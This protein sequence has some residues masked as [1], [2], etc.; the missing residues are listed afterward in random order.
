MV[1]LI[2]IKEKKMKKNFLKV[3]ALLIAA[4]LMV[5]SCTQEVAPV[6]NGLVEVTL[7]TSAARS[8]L[9]YS[10]LSINDVTYRYKLTAQWTPTGDQ[11]AVVGNTENK[12]GAVEGYVALTKGSTSA[13][14]GYVSQGLWEVEVIGSINGTDVLKGTTQVYFNKNNDKVTVYVKPTDTTNSAQIKL[15]VKVNDHD[16]G[17]DYKLYYTIEDINGSVVTGFEEEE[18]TRADVTLQDENKKDTGYRSWTA[19]ATG[20]TSGYYRVTVTMKNTKEGV[21][22][23]EQIVGG[24]TKG[25]LLFSGDTT[26]ELN[27]S[28]NSK[29][30][31]EGTLNVVYPTVSLSITS[32]DSGTVGTAIAFTAVPVTSI[33]DS[34]PL[35]YAIS[36]PTYTWY[37]N[38]KAVSGENNSATYSPNYSTP[39]YKTVTCVVK[40]TLTIPNNASNST[41]NVKI[42]VQADA[43]K[44]VLIN[45]STT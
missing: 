41:D 23:A 17:S 37:E 30:F 4:M 36:D 31:V 43:G 25:V 26:A 32:A 13:T 8:A 20:L 1:F 40:Y 11:D 44:T 27:G 14:L 18:M 2:R 9:V 5:V 42:V 28:V 34:L 19:T 15:N 16:A 7:N 10:G 35:G 29:D 45:P 22:E 39:G 33:T 12:T 38:G 24:I 6:D 21:A 3:A